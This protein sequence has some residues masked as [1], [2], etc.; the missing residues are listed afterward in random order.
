[1]CTWGLR[2]TCWT[3]K[4]EIQDVVITQTSSRSAEELLT[5]GGKALFKEELL[6]EINAV[7]NEETKTNEDVKQNI[8]KQ[9]YFTTFVIK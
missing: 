1:M 8:I 5:V 9:L 6:D 2:G 3:S 7:I 4:T